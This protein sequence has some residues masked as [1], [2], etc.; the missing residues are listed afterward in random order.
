MFVEEISYTELNSRRFRVSNIFHASMYVYM[1]ISRVD[2][3]YE[4]P[5][6]QI[7]SP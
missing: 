7:L 6:G 1:F 4:A 3:S 5:K 2:F